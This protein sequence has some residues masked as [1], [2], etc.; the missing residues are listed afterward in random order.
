MSREFNASQVVGFF[1]WV[2][3][4]TELYMYMGNL[5]QVIPVLLTFI[6][7]SIRTL[8]SHDQLQTTNPRSVIYRKHVRFRMRV[9]VS[10]TLR[11][12]CSLTYVPSST[13]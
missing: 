10:V 12:A 7:L 3:S 13:S 4:D 6:S 11:N 9:M 5:L 1:S 2:Y 8:F